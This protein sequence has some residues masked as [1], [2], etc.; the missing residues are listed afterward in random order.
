MTDAKPLN[1]KLLIA[2][3]G[4]G[5]HVFPALA[6]ARE[7]LSRKGEREVVFVGT[8]RGIEARLVPEAG[9]PLETI[10]S[11]GLKGMGG[12]K[13]ARNTAKLFPAMWDSF[14]I[15]A[16]AQIHSGAGGWR[17]R[18]RADDACRRSAR[19]ANGGV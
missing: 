19:I 7:W 10:R 5:G 6:I 18:R 12:M 2:G 14:A 15:L 9:F 8:K 3:G 13:L 1:G 11:A 17:I 4:T 16:Q